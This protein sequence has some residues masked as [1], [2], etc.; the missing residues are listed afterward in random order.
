MTNAKDPG[1]VVGETAGELATFLKTFSVY[2]VEDD[3][4]S[5]RLSMHGRQIACWGHNSPE[6]I[7]M[8]K[9]EAD[10]AALAA[11]P[12]PQDTLV[13]ETF[14]AWRWK[15]RGRTDV[16]AWNYQFGHPQ[17]PEDVYEVERVYSETT[18]RSLSEANASAAKCCDSYAAENQ[19]LFDR[20][21]T[22]EA[23]LSAAQAE[24]ARLKG[25]L[26]AVRK[27]MVVVSEYDEQSLMIQSIDAAL[28]DKEAEQGGGE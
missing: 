6:G 17:L 24:I 15:P 27:H 18:V 19:R 22:A 5:I 11:S 26:G 21:E 4:E 25:A 1:G 8:L 3:E 12:L 13:G 2:T 16:D 14:V 7:A 10:R 23:Q 28:A 20:A 9:F